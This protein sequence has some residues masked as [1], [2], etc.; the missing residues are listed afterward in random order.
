MKAGSRLHLSSLGILLGTTLCVGMAVQAEKQTTPVQFSA[1]AHVIPQQQG[2]STVSQTSAME[3]DTS[4]ERMESARRYLQVQP[5]EPLIR[6]GTKDFATQLPPEKRLAF[7][8]YMTDLLNLKEL[9]HMT[10]TLLAEHFTTQ[11][12]D[13]M[14]RFYASPEG[15]SITRK[16][17]AYMVDC[18]G[19]VASYMNTVAVSMNATPTEATAETIPMPQPSSA[20]HTPNTGKVSKPTQTHPAKAHH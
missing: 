18:M 17:P 15:R 14:T 16:M 11:E 13:A 3:D 4:S 9:E 19:Q 12:I 7:E 5:L 1:E 10:Q 8:T 20:P 6:Q 2:V